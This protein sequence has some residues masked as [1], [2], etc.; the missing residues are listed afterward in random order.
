MI[1]SVGTVSGRCTS[2]W[3]QMPK[4]AIT[5]RDGE[6]LFSPRKIVRCPLVSIDFS[7]VE[8]RVQALY[9]ILVNDPDL[10]MLR[11]YSPYKCHRLKQDG[12][13]EE[14]DYTNPEHVSAWNNKNEDGTSIWSHI[15]DNQLWNL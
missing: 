2:D 3:Q 12:T 13:Y 6:E 14:Y 7:Q 11:A 9:T 8:L 10:N 5:T 15:E 1:N 4:D